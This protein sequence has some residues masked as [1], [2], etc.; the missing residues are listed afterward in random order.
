MLVTFQHFLSN[1]WKCDSST[2]KVNSDVKRML[3]DEVRS[4]CNG[5]FTDQQIN[6]EWFMY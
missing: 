4:G 5:D 2:D 3:M 6:R 1:F